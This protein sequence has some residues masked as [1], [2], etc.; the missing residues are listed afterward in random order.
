MECGGRKTTT[1][2]KSYTIQ[3]VGW[4]TPNEFMI[5]DDCGHEHFFREHANEYFCTEKEYRKIKLKKL[6]NVG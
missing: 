2:G 6:N 3:R 1:I 5:I 4:N